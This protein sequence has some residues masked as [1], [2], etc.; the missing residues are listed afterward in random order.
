MEL[1]SYEENSSGKLLPEKIAVYTELGDKALLRIKS[2]TFTA[3]PWQAE[4]LE[5]KLPKG[6][7]KIRLDRNGY[8]RI[9]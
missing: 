8:V 9:D 2:R 1:S 7:E 5:L 3:K 6:S 4:A